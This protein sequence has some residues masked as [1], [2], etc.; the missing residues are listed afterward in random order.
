MHLSKLLL[1]LRALGPGL[2][3]VT[4]AT[5]Q[6]SVSFDA[7]KT[8]PNPSIESEYLYQAWIDGEITVA[9]SPELGSASLPQI[10]TLS[11]TPTVQSIRMPDGSAGRAVGILTSSVTTAVDGEI[12]G[13]RSRE[14]QVV[15]ARDTSVIET[16]LGRL[17]LLLALSW[18]A[19]S[20]FCAGILSWV[21]RRGLNP[22]TDLCRQIERVDVAQL[23]RRFQVENSPVE[24]SVVMD[25]LNQ[26]VDRIRRALDREQA[27]AADVAHELRTPLTGLMMS[28]EVA[29]SRRREPDEYRKTAQQCLDICKEMQGVVEALME[30]ANPASAIMNA[31]GADVVALHELVAECAEPFQ[32]EIDRRQLNLQADIDDN[33]QIERDAHYLRRVVSNLIDN[34]T[35]YAD[36]GSTIIVS[37]RHTGTGAELCV[38][39]DASDAPADV[40][41]HAFDAFWRADSSRYE[42]SRHAGLGLSLCRRIV[43]QIG[44]TITACYAEGRFSAKIWVPDEPRE[45]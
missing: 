43:D 28:L 10:E 27:F 16:T 6:S 9:R 40:T 37:G 14:I 31:G 3:L 18:V 30:L 15:I 21:V 25:E 29:L 2:L 7:S 13:H 1:P 24:L 11:S 39:N 36:E 5:G 17:R 42:V 22:L 23:D 34:A 38:T 12:L 4:A 8:V 33:V 44:G 41:K 45:T 35:H 32:A 26:M 19:S 20:L